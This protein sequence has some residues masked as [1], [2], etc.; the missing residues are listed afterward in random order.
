MEEI[1]VGLNV[2]DDDEYLVYRKKMTPILK[3][4]GGGFR[5]DFLVSKT[6]KSET[7]EEINRVFV[8]YFPNPKSQKAFFEDNEYLAVKREHFESSVASTTI[9]AEFEK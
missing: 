8:I 2:I 7:S 4:Y 3:N 1:L 9:I 6:L 5:Y